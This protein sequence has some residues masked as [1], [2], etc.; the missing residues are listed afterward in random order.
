MKLRTYAIGFILLPFLPLVAFPQNG[1]GL[2]T[3]TYTNFPAVI[4]AVDERTSSLNQQMDQQTAKYLNKLDQ[5][6]NKL[7]LKL[8]KYDS[9]SAG[10]LA[11][12]NYNSLISRMPASGYRSIAQ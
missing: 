12:N 2:A 11:P 5:L 1:N 6:E 8:A 4:K 10:P 7:R 3:N 9:A